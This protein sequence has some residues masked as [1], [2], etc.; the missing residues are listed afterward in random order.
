MRSSTLLTL[1][2]LLLAAPLA[3]GGATREALTE[4]D[5]IEAVYADWRSAVERADIA[6]YVAVLHDDVR[7]LPPDAEPIVGSGSYEAFLKPVFAA[8]DYRIEVIRSPEI[9]VFG[10]LALAEY[11]YVIHLHLKNPAAGVEQPGALTAART[12]ARYVD[13][14]RRDAAGVWT[15][16]R[17]A[18]QNMAD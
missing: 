7:L 2:G 17:H 9:E 4:V 13:V 11:E 8:A 3:A 15:V 18:W 10:D 16:Y 1:C 12:R 5:A 6:G 14:L